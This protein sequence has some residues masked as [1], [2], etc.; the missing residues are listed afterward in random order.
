M[1]NS[2]NETGREQRKIQTNGNKTQAKRL[3]NNKI[4]N[5]RNER[6]EEHPDYIR[7]LNGQMNN[8]IQN[9]ICSEIIHSMEQMLNFFRFTSFYIVHGYCVCCMLIVI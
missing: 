4:K 7:T 6:M 8:V 1:D 9:K 2:P 5:K 3:N